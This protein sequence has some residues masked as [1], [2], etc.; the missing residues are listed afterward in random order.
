MLVMRLHRKFEVITALVIS[1]NWKFEVITTLVMKPNWKFEVIA[2]L[3]MKPNWEFELIT[4]LVIRP[5][6][7]CE[8]VTTLAMMRY[9]SFCLPVYTK[10]GSSTKYRKR[11]PT[12][13]NNPG[14]PPDFPKISASSVLSSL[15]KEPYI[16]IETQT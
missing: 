5:N 12:E 16:R 15:S 1:P 3:V 4:I 9:Y 11:E 7:K 8:V 10:T 2:T 13:A 6:W 14:K